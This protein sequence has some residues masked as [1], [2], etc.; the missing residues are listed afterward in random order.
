MWPAKCDLSDSIA[1]QL[2]A[3][4]KTSTRGSTRKLHAATQR[5]GCLTDLHD[6][7]YTRQYLHD[8]SSLCATIQCLVVPHL[9]W[10]TAPGLVTSAPHNR[11]P[12]QRE[13]FSFVVADHTTVD[14]TTV[15]AG[16]SRT[17]TTGIIL[18]V[19][20]IRQQ[21]QLPSSPTPSGSKGRPTR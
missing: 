7:L 1:K 11:G 21:E 15:V 3:R 17:T 10:R 9:P 6:L 14:H 16:N 2:H 12:R 5:S 4:K 20:R 19:A 18:A 13:L 8:I